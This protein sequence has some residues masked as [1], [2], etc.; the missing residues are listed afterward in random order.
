MP[1]G[2]FVLVYRSEATSEFPSVVPLI[3][4]LCTRVHVNFTRIYARAHTIN[5]INF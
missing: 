4:I 2:S 1:H 5:V 3:R